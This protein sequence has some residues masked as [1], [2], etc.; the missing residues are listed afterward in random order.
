MHEKRG[1]LRH[2]LAK[3]GAPKWS[4][5]GKK[6]KRKKDQEEEMIFFLFHSVR[7]RAF[8]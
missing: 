7:K 8:L 2:N 1:E 3:S 6:K 5:Q 4:R